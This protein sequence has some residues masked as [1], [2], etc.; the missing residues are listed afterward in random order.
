MQIYIHFKYIY[1]HFAQKN[2]LLT[3]AWIFGFP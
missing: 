1:L 2:D 3:Y